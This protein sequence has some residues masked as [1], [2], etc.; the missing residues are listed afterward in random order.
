MLP[1]PCYQPSPPRA[2]GAILPASVSAELARLEAEIGQA[3]DPQARARLAELGEAAASRALRKIWENR[4]GVRRLS[5][6]IMRMAEREAM[7]RNA[8]GISPA[9]SAACSFRAASQDESMTGPL[10]DNDVQMEVQSPAPGIAFGLS[11]QAMIEPASPVQKM[12]CRLQNEQR[13]DACIVP[14]LDPG[15]MEL[16]S[17]PSWTSRRG[18]QNQ[19]C[20]SPVASSVANRGRAEAGFPENEMPDSP[21]RDDTPSPVREITRRVRQMDGPSGCA[22]VATPPILVTGNALRETEAPPP[23]TDSTARGPISFPSPQLIAL[24]ELE[25]L[26]VFLIYVYLA[27]KKIEE[28]LEDVNYIRYLKSLPMDCFESEIWNR[29]GHESLPASERRKNLDWDPSKT[30]LYYCIL[31]KRHD[32]IVPIFKGPYVDNTRT[33]LQKTVGD[34]NVLI[35]KLDDIDGL[36]NCADDFG[37]YCMYYRQVLEDDINFSEVNVRIIED[38]PC[39]DEHGNIVPNDDGEPL[40]HTDGTGLISFDLAIKCPVNVFKGNFLKGHELQDTGDSKKHRYLISYPLLIQFRMFYNG[41]AVKGTVLADKRLPENTIHIRPSMIKIN[42]DSSSLGGR[43]FNSF[44]VVTTSNR[45]RR[46][47]TS[48]FLIAL[49]CYGGVPAGYFM[50]LLGKALEDANKA[51]N[52]AGDSLEVALNHADMDDLISARM[53]LAGIQP[54]DEAFLQYQLDIMT[55]QERKG[56]LQGRIPIDD[57]CYLMGTTDP[58]GTLKPDQVCVIHDNRQVS[59]KV[60][61]Y[62]HPGQ[63]FGDIHKLTATHIDG[64]EEIVGDS[65]YAIFFPTSGPR[66]LADEMANSDFDGDIYWVSWNQQLLKHFKPGIPWEHK[67][68]PK[69]TKQK[70]PQDYDG[71]ELESLLFCEFLR[72]RF[73]PSYVLGTAANCWLTLMDRL[74]TP[75]VPQSEKDI[76]K[77]DML[78]LVDIY[79][80]ALDAP[81]NGNKI[82]VPQRLMVKKYPHFLEREPSYHSTSLLG[83]IY[84]QAKSQQSETVPPIKISPLECFA[85]EAVSEDYKCCWRNLY[86]KYLKESS[87]LCKLADKEERNF[88]F[89]ELYQDY[90]RILYE[91]EELEASPRS[92]LDLFNEACAIYQVVYEHAAPRNE[93]SKCGFAWKVAGRAL[94]ELYMLKHGGERVTCLRSALEDAFKKNRAEQAHRG[95]GVFDC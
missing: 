19:P 48:R 54:E 34:D 83:E 43:S 29:F 87:A 40:I 64:L 69:N 15:G 26:R 8:A 32:S 58:T 2:R 82:K 61:V 4:H 10:Y 89:R 52:K 84:D 70:K 51:R 55:K 71:L 85:K 49:L 11:N 68:Q 12:P 27:D 24:G 45:P 91:A 92:R 38:E 16:E 35:V 33:H 42:A 72:A 94:C 77:M 79:Y 86:P 46:A 95:V 59:G 25:F 41:N 37:M 44:E 53:I 67:S 74:L 28:V 57:C 88:R 20:F 36:T 22:G 39:K 73:S 63:H 7:E 56:F 50:E 66:S 5:P 23:R 47:H 1:S 80:W 31:Q 78:E 13:R 18:L 90:K 9:E 62:K 65:K 14:V 81:K 6:Y 76:I 21:D 30:R 17:P 93:V 60:L 3:A 75:G